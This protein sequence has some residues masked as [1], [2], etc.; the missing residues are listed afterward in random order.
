MKNWPDYIPIDATEAGRKAVRK[1]ELQRLRE[2]YVDRD[3]EADT[4]IHNFKYPVYELSSTRSTCRLSDRAVLPFFSGSSFNRAQADAK[5]K[6]KREQEIA[7]GVRPKDSEEPKPRTQ[8]EVIRSIEKR[9]KRRLEGYRLSNPSKNKIKEKVLS[10]YYAKRDT[11]FTFL[12]LTVIGD[13]DD[14]RA[15]LLWNKF[16]TVMFKRWGKFNYLRVCE[17]QKNGRIHFHIVMDRRFPIQRLNALWIIQQLNEGVRNEVAD[18]KLMAET[19][20]TFE[21]LYRQGS[22]GAE[23][24]GKYLNPVDIKKIT[25]VGNVLSY[26]TKYIT[27]N[28]G[29]FKCGVWRCNHVV[30]KLYT[31]QLVPK[32]VFDKCAT[33]K[34]ISVNKKTGEVYYCRT[35]Y[36]GFCVINSIHNKSY[37][38]RW[39]VE[40]D[41]LNRWI[42]EDCNQ[43]SD[44]AIEFGEWL[45]RPMFYPYF[46]NFNKN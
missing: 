29:S 7:A 5:R 45:F 27:K 33:D 25:S 15:V 21:Q 18:L 2:K 6:E 9:R 4:I 22:F 20:Q 38:R 23:V 41:Q 34:N 43:V 46:E 10:L 8:A 3:Q 42:L 35:Y 13:C 26:I 39:M 12:T 28:K 19:G 14:R 36:G 11:G 37:F 17:R 16:R 24:M 30:S 1:A 40:L 32:K 44:S 31:K